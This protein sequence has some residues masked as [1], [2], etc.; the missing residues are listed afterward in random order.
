VEEVDLLVEG[1]LLDDEIG[2]LV[3]GERG[4]HPGAISSVR[5][6]GLGAHGQDWEKY[7]CA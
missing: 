4:V 1:E 7:C 3:R 5:D 6:G 2:A